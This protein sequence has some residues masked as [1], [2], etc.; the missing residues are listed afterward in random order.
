MLGVTSGTLRPEIASIAVPTTVDDS[1]MHGDDFDLNADWGHFGSG[2]A[3]MPGQGR[4][5]ERPYTEDGQSVLGD[6][7]FDVYLNDRAYWKNVPS[8][9]WNYK[10]G[11]CQVPRKWLSYRESRV[12]GRALFSDDV[13]HLTD[14]ARR[15]TAIL[16]QVNRSR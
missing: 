13:Q 1:N 16:E 4:V 5:T 2:Q 9:V 7:T 10:L 8:T 6:T 3:V 15:I 14:T 12:L 11:G